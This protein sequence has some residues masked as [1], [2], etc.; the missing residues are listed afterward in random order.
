MRV[1]H[2]NGFFWAAKAAAGSPEAGPVASTRA[3]VLQGM[4]D[5][6]AKLPPNEL[7]AINDAAYS[8]MLRQRGEAITALQAAG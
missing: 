8:A 6:L 1:F 5:Y 2:A 4:A 7:E 3:E